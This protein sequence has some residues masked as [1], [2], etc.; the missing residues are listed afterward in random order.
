MI[1]HEAEGVDTM[2][3][4]LDPLLEQE[5]ETS[6]VSVIE[7]DGLPRVAAQGDMIECPWIVDSGLTG[8]GPILN[9]KLQRCKPDPTWAHMGQ[10][11]LSILSKKGWYD[12]RVLEIVH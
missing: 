5:I 6:P 10:V 4:P 8:H 9:N 7:E 11:L 12:I 1:A 3:E 2:P